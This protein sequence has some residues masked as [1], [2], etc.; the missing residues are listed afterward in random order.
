MSIRSQA[1]NS[2]YRSQQAAPI[3]FKSEYST[4]S[5]DDTVGHILSRLDQLQA[6]ISTQPDTAV[7]PHAAERP[8]AARLVS[9]RPDPSDLH[10]RLQHLEA[11]HEVCSPE[12]RFGTLLCVC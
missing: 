8:S 4:A 1:A 5:H 10:A 7:A 9:S 11:I 6:S 12:P 3:E 2:T